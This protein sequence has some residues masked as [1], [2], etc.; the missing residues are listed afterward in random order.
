MTLP[1]ALSVARASGDRRFG[2]AIVLAVAYGA[3]VGG[4]GTPVGTPPNL[5]GIRAMRAAHL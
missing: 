3:S 2:A 5:I 4:I 1:I